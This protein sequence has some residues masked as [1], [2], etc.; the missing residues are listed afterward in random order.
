MSIPI[1]Y[2]II[3]N[4]SIKDFSKK[5]FSNYM[6]KDVVAIFGKS[7][8]NCRIEESCNWSIELLISGAFDKF[9]EKVFSISI[10]N[11]NI[12]NPLLPKYLH[13]RYSIFN[14][15][16]SKYENKLDLRNNQ[17]IEICFVN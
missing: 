10:K 5:T 11:I 17:V 13:K 12:N 3:D 4:R 15:Y 7:L 8:M 16:L 6:L 9:W 2:R 1:D 14:N